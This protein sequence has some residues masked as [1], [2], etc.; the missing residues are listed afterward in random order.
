MRIAGWI[1]DRENKTKRNEI[2]R[3]LV[4]GL[5]FQFPVINAFLSDSSV[6]V[7]PKKVRAEVPA[8]CLLTK[9]FVVPVSDKS[10]SAAE[11]FIVKVVC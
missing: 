5:S 11:K 9:A 3:T 7:D 8:N 4:C 6:L 2:N 1:C 10:V